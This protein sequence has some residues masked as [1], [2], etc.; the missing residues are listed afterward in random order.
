MQV[1][2]VEGVGIGCRWLVGGELGVAGFIFE[3][4]DSGFFGSGVIDESLLA[5]APRAR[6]SVGVAAVRSTRADAPSR[7]SP[8]SEG[9]L[10]PGGA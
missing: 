6:R 8:R 7:A 3:F 2:G 9:A 10:A 5:A 1:V 4:G